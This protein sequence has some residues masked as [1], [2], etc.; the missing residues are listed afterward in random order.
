MRHRIFRAL[1]LFLAGWPLLM[2]EGMCVCRLF[3][4]R[5]RASE[6]SPFQQSD[7]HSACCQCC[8]CKREKARSSSIDHR[9]PTNEQHAPAC[10]AND[11]ED[12]SK[13]P[14]QY[15]LVGNTAVAVTAL[16]LFQDDLS[17]GHRLDSSPLL[18][19]TSD[20]PIYLSLCTLVI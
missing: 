10:P 16:P 6:S 1:V 3:Q 12:H 7:D 18:G 13:L 4:N 19:H 15:Q 14:G 9:L 8:R 20:R 17:L 2:P 5:T 11:K